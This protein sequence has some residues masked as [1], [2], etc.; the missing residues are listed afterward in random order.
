MNNTSLVKHKFFGLNICIVLINETFCILVTYPHE[1][2]S[3]C[4]AVIKNGRRIYTF[5]GIPGILDRNN[6]NALLLSLTFYIYGE[7]FTD[8]MCVSHK[9]MV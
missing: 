3:E 4:I 6:Y 9:T 5:S 2:I 1:Y 7:N 8:N